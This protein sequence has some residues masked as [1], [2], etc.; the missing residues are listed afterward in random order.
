MDEQG[1]TALTLDG[2]HGEGG[3][4]I[5]RTALSLAVA[6]TR[7]VTIVNVRAGRPRPG[8]QPQHLTAV[9][10]LAAVSDAEVEGAELGSTALRFVPRRIG[11]GMYRFEVG[12]AGAVSLIFQALLLPLALVDVPSRLTLVG[13]THVTWSPPFHYLAETFL[14]AL[15]AMG[16]RAELAL[17][18][19]GWYPRG[20][21]EVEATIVP[22]PRTALRGFVAE[23]RDETAPIRGVSAVSH[24][25]RS[26]AERQQR[27]VAERLAAAGVTAKIAIEEAAPAFGAGTLVFLAIRGRAGFSALGRRGLPAEDVA[28][29]AVEPLLAYLATRAAVDGHLADQLVPFCALAQ[30]ESTFT[31][32]AISGHLTTVAWVVEQLLPV[33]VHL[34]ALQ[35]ARV[36]ITP[37]AGS[38]PEERR[39]S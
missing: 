20:G 12:T 16:I 8:L 38:M 34:E 21:G 9:R 6:V 37:A 29:A 11:G 35:P 19:W 7:P 23:A 4:Q 2:S 18:R 24:L 25:P 27:R 33:R 31:C 36:R 32:P 13:G 26:I 10:A 17:R 14:P 22:T 30:A 3:G 5:L 15:A 39:S 1:R 28:D